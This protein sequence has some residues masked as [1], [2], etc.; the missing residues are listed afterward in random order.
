MDEKFLG[1]QSC[2][3]RLEIIG[4]VFGAPPYTFIREVHLPSANFYDDLFQ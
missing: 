4:P 3:K 1:E 2:A